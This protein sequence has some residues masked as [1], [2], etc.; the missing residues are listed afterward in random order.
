MFIAALRSAGPRS[1][2]P[3]RS[4]NPLPIIRGTRSF[5]DDPL[6]K[7]LLRNRELS[8]EEAVNEL[9]WIREEAREDIQRQAAAIFGVSMPKKEDME[10]MRGLESGV[11]LGLVERRAQGEPLQYILGN[12]DFGPLQLIC[13]PPT[14]IPRPETAHIFTRLSDE[15][16]SASSAS[17]EH[18]SIVDLC[19]GSGCI[20][21]LLSHTL[22]DR[23]AHAFGFELS[24]K[25]LQLARD[26]AASLG[27]RNTSFSQLDI[28]SPTAVSDILAATKGKVSVLTA[29]PPYISQ[30]EYEQLP[31]SVRRYEDPR[32][33]LGDTQDGD[34]EGLA[35]YGR[36]A[37]MLPDLLLDDKDMAG[38]GWASAPRVVMEIGESQGEDVSQILYQAGDGS[39]FTRTEI[40]Q[41][42]YGK[43]RAVVGWSG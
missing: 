38:K 31:D 41:D 15:L 4:L 11:V 9:R 12:V 39:M 35:F 33:L 34:G 37:D 18:L 36:I 19:S 7:T 5:S 42:Q 40:W 32:A 6:L 25:A 22:Q 16:R 20:P 3:R 27:I 10:A 29:N 23:L 26:N 28:L 30:A 1:I 2:A 17:S 43:D 14:L 8:R 13:R 24:S 21:L